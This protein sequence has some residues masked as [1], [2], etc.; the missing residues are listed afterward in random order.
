[1]KIDVV[2]TVL[3]QDHPV[4]SKIYIDPGMLEKMMSP[5]NGIRWGYWLK[6]HCVCV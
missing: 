5:A 1:M 6:H 4:V 3:E 2:K